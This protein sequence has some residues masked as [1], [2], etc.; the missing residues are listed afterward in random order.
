MYPIGLLINITYI[1]IIKIFEI[2]SI[3]GKL[4]LSVIINIT[5]IVSDL[6]E[7]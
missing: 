5:Y 4:T 2:L 7:K 6:F 1:V 3:H